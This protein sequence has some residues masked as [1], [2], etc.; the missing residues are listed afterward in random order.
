MVQRLAF[1][2]ISASAT[3]RVVLIYGTAINI[4]RLISYTIVTRYS[5]LAS[6]FKLVR[7]ISYFKVLNENAIDPTCY[8]VAISY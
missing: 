7:L 5:L 2:W 4:N 1:A 8:M 3:I 6:H